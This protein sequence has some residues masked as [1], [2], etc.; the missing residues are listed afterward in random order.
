MDELLN[1]IVRLQ[2]EN[3]A[4]KHRVCCTDRHLNFFVDANTLLEHQ[5]KAANRHFERTLDLYKA[6]MQSK[7]EGNILHVYS[8][9]YHL[10]NSN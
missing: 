10:A 1:E 4:L 9:G 8:R 3:E 2:R 7:S 6:L 5:L